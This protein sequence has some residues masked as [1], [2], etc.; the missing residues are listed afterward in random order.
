MV[1]SMGMARVRYP[2]CS[3][4]QHVLKACEIQLCAALG[5]LKV[6]DGIFLDRAGNRGHVSTKPGRRRTYSYTSSSGHAKPQAGSG[7]YDRFRP[8][9]RQLPVLQQTRQQMGA[10]ARFAGATL[11]VPVGQTP[12]GYRPVSPGWTSQPPPAAPPTGGYVSPFPSFP[13]PM[14]G[15]PEVPIAPV[16]VPPCV[17]A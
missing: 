2:T 5:Q 6:D 1:L 11:W 10:D 14:P 7:V 9:S 17:F 15:I 16:E 8:F 4:R 13:P 3:K 12:P